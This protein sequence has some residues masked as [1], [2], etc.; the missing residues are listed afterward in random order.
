MP[1]IVDHAAMRVS[2]LTRSRDLFASKGFAAVTMRG[3]AREA[4]VSTGTLYHYFATKEELFAKL[5]ERAASEDIRDALA[6]LP[7]AADTHERIDSFLGFV[8]LAEPR[9]QQFLLLTLDYVRHVDA[10]ADVIV[11]SLRAYRETIAEHLAELP[12]EFAVLLLD[13]VIGRLV[14]RRLDPDLP[15]DDAQAAM[16]RALADTLPAP[17]G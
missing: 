11:R 14:Q 15:F 4:G 17:A 10:P 8:R 3:I 12:G 16:L 1:K 5:V 7:Q 9:L 13:A 2:I 6:S